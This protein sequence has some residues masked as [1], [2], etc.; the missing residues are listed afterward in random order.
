M[1]WLS[2][3]VMVGT[4]KVRRKTLRRKVVGQICC[5]RRCGVTLWDGAGAEDVAGAGR[6][7]GLVCETMRWQVIERRWC[8]ARASWFWG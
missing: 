6:E 3:L 7:S 8:W 5:G 1:R 4:D 2:C